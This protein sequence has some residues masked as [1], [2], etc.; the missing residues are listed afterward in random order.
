M[1]KETQKQSPFI[2]AAAVAAG[3]QAGIAQQ[4]L[5]AANQNFRTDERAWIVPNFPKEP[6]APY[7]GIFG[8]RYIAHFQMKN[9][10]K[11]VAKDVDGAVAVIILHKDEHI[12]ISNCLKS[13]T[14]TQLAAFFPDVTQHA[15]PELD[16]VVD[17]GQ[18]L[19]P[20]KL[21]QDMI[22]ALNQGERFSVGCGKISYSDIFSPLIR[23]YVTFCEVLQAHPP[24]AP[25]SPTGD[26]KSPRI[27]Q[28]CLKLNAID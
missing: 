20:I 6:P 23:H 9:E 25:V 2:Q 1:L 28:E 16:E 14:K 5:N 21:D 7:N 22:Q 8:I 10:G 26:F 4:S 12:L 17:D 3:Q 24:P 19:Q 11:T 27:Y 13:G 15:F 18:R